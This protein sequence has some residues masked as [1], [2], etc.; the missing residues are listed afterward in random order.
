MVITISHAGYIK[1]LPVTTYRRQARGGRGKSGQTTRELDFLE[2]MF[3]ASTHDYILFYT[4]KGRLYW[5]KVYEIPQAGRTAQGKAMATMAAGSL[6]LALQKSN[7]EAAGLAI[8]FDAALMLEAQT[9]AVAA[10]AS[11]G[12]PG[13]G[14][15]IPPELQCPLS[16]ELMID[17]VMNAAGRLPC[18][19]RS[20]GDA[21]RRPWLGT[22]LQH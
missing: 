3:I 22:S 4:E 10:N 6:A 19:P 21:S 15:E 20:G 8:A 16:L 18:R 13:A 12:E 9:P 14:K 2:H 17:P 7:E 1:R 11:P 5:L